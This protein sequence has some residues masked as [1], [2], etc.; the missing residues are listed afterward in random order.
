MITPSS[1]GSRI[2]TRTLS[3][4]ESIGW[5]LFGKKQSPSATDMSDP[6]NL[7]APVHVALWGQIGNGEFGQGGNVVVLESVLVPK[8]TVPRPLGVDS[9]GWSTTLQVSQSPYLQ[10]KKASSEL[11]RL[12]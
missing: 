11:T 4:L 6:G 2:G 7:V 10:G 3:A 1:F 12:V 9:P 5:N 8:A